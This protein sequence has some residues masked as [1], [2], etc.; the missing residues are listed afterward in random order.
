M[1]KFYVNHHHVAIENYLFVNA[2]DSGQEHS[3]QG[4]AD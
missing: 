2:S 4:R 3:L 1:Y